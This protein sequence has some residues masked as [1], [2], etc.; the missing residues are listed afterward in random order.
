MGCEELTVRLRGQ[1]SAI[2]HCERI[3]I[4]VEAAFA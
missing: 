4:M 2:A 1:Q 3:R